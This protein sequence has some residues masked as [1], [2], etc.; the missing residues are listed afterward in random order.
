M[1]SLFL[2]RSISQVPPKLRRGEIIQGHE[3]QEAGI[4]WTTLEPVSTSVLYLDNNSVPF[5]LFKDVT[6]VS[7]MIK[8]SSE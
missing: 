6:S 4:L 8:F 2:F 7:Y 1:P 3:H 5:C